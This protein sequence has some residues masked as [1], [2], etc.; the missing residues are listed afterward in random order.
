[1]AATSTAKPRPDTAGASARSA[2]GLSAR[3]RGMAFMVLLV[4]EL[5]DQGIW[6]NASIERS[7][8]RH[9]IFGVGDVG[10]EATIEAW[11]E[12][13][14]KVKQ[15]RADA[16]ERGIARW[17]VIKKRRGS[18]S[19]LAGYAVT[20]ARVFI[21]MAR[22]LERLEHAQEDAQAAY[23]RGFARGQAAARSAVSNGLVG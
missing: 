20:E 8:R 18:A 14:R 1:M 21:E 17:A 16:A 9:D 3:R 7:H 10:L 13:D 2:A 19:P 23:D 5:R 6:P 4:Q 22:E 11:S 15:A 12:I